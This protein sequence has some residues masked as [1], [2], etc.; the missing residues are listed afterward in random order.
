M[1]TIT[2]G[3]NGISIAKATIGIPGLWIAE[4]TR[5]YGFYYLTLAF[6]VAAYFVCRAGDRQPLR[7]GCWWPFVKTT[8]G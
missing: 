6:F 8:N 4:V 2:G 3:D 1:T 5:P 7:P